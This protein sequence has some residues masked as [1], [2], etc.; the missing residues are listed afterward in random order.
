MIYVISFL[1]G[2]FGSGIFSYVIY[3]RGYWKGWSH[4][5]DVK[6]EDCKQLWLE[7]DR[8]NYEVEGLRK[9]LLKVDKM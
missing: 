3:K 7:N 8:L 1:V 9:Q 4:G 6:S 2:C 5:Y